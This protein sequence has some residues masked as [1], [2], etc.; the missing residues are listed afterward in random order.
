MLC[1]RL[2]AQRAVCVGEAGAQP[3][4]ATGYC[5]ASPGPGLGDASGKLREKD[6]EGARGLRERAASPRQKGSQEGE[7]A[8]LLHGKAPACPLG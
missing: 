3:L 8:S 7:R 2:C 5:C 1:G 4:V 6:R